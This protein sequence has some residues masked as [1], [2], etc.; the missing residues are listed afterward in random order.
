MKTGHRFFWNIF[1]EVWTDIIYLV[2]VGIS[3]IDLTLAFWEE[4]EDYVKN[5]GGDD[6]GEDIVEDE[7]EVHLAD[8]VGDGG[9]GEVVDRQV[10]LA[11]PVNV[12][13][14]IVYGTISAR[15]LIFHNSG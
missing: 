3:F 15:V 14:E 9:G 4:L 11:V 6:C 7:E 13:V 10:S 8:V 2:F 5:D 12:F 1:E